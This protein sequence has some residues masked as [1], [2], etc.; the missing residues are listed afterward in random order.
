[1]AEV[2]QEIL[3]EVDV[4]LNQMDFFALSIYNIISKV[5][6]AKV[7][8]ELDAFYGMW[9]DK[10][11]AIKE[12]AGLKYSEIEEELKSRDIEIAR[13]K[14]EISKVEELVKEGLNAKESDEYGEG[15]E[16]I[17]N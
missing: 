13:L 17:N 3:S 12:T 5:P 14:D 1:M 7:K 8:E 15:K 10:Q 4:S 9:K 11:K 16:G 6:N 2:K